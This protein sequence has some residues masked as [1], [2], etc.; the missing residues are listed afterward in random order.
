MLLYSFS[1]Y[2]VRQYFIN[3]QC[4]SPS[5][6][7]WEKELLIKTNTKDQS[8][9][10]VNSIVRVFGKKYIIVSIIPLLETLV[11]R[12]K[13]F[14]LSIQLNLLYILTKSYVKI[15]FRILQPIL[16]GQLIQYFGDENPVAT[17][18]AYM[19]GL[20]LVLCL[21][22]M[23]ITDNIYNFESKLVGIQMRIACCSL[24]YKKVETSLG[25]HVI[26]NT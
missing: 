3:F 9:S 10:L 19:L 5:I 24:M 23:M 16:L 22:S 13:I 17:E 20:A 26:F 8:A 6:R 15:T 11:F 25:K 7:E 12:Q 2:S 18:T 1:I 4:L 21:V 14:T